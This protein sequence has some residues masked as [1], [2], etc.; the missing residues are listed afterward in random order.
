MNIS[1]LRGFND[2]VYNLID[3][4]SFEPSRFFY[5][6]INKRN[7][8]DKW[9]RTNTNGN[10]LN[11]DTLLKRRSVNEKYKKLVFWKD[12]KHQRKEALKAYGKS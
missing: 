5:T 3:F 2:Y 7:N 6:P 9:I 8:N 10:F 11:V 12:I 1:T 4:T